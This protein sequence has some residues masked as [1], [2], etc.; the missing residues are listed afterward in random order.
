MKHGALIVLTTLL[1]AASLFGQEAVPF[2]APVG[3][4]S[5]PWQFSKEHS[6]EFNGADV[7]RKKW[8][9]DTKDFGPWSW[10]PE[11]VTQND[12]SLH[13]QM[14]HQD[15]QRGQQTLHYKSG[16]A[17]NDRTITYG[18]FEARLK[19]CSRYPGAC[20]SFWLYSIGPQ[21][22]YAA[23]DG[24]TVAYSEIDVVELQQSEFDFTAKKHFPVT[25]I[26]CNLHTTLI[27]DGKRV[28][29]RPGNRPEICANHFDSPWDPRED[30]HVYGV[31]NTRDWIT[32]YIDGK[33][34]A[35]KPNL[36]WHLPMHV[37]LSLGLRY[38][39]VAYQDGGR[40]TV[41]EK[42]T[43]DGFP[44]TMSVDYVRVWQKPADAAKKSPTDWSRDEY[45]A[46]EKAKWEKNDSTWNQSRVESNFA[47]IDTNS[48]DVASGKERQIWFARKKAASSE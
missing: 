23:R 43:A 32:W 47:E 42:T 30:F 20:P 31:E 39:F 22:R 5:G 3:A 40:K 2:G 4:T 13:I 16:L 44:T 27:Q 7:D 24:E 48:D 17:R 14:V 33:E 12:G 21:N 8:N 26:D 25:R 45:I 19:G 18:Y 15:H 38:P 29:A 11:H 28:W 34:V 10:E 35:R 46:K 41:P 9:I 37:T 1:Q 6:D 36:Y